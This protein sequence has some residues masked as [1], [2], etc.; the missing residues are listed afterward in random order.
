LGSVHTPTVEVSYD[1]GT[2]WRATNVKRAN[3]TWTVT[4][5]HP[6][7]AEFVSLRANVSD[8]DGNSEKVT[9]IRAYALK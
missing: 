4:V 1:D 3:G 9:I 8:Q 2:T 7:D 6:G 5:D